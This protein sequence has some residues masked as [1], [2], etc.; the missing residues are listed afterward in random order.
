MAALGLDIPQPGAIPAAAAI[1]TLDTGRT[2]PSC[3]VCADPVHLQ[4]G[5]DHARLVPAA[6]LQLSEEDA[7]V[8]ITALNRLVSDDGIDF[9]RGRSAGHWYLSGL[10]AAALASWPTHVIAHRNAGDFVQ[11][12][13]DAAAWQRLMT[14]VQMLL[15]A[16]PLNS[17]RDERGL[18]AI[19]GVWFWGGAQLPAQQP[20]QPPVRQS[21]SNPSPCL[22]RLFSDDLFAVGLAQHVGISVQPLL[23]ASEI[24]QQQ[25]KLAES[26]VIVDTSLY[27][28][29]LSGDAE[30]I[31]TSRAHCEALWLPL[32]QSALAAG[33]FS[34]VVVDG[35]NEQA[36][37]L[38]N[39]P[40][41]GSW[42]RR[43]FG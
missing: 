14:E 33:C 2:L 27:S 10:P 37:V 15:H 6:A 25:D 21:S 41:R 42:F 18:P 7:D 23:N 35:C 9:S 11:R 19:N 1:Y 28:A 24:M 22:T 17:D 31:Q 8:L 40:R 20:A 3:I 16:H 5:S 32:L 43:L 38:A 36:L 4:A 13:A 30:A 29:W 12:H 39:Q 34:Q 26:I